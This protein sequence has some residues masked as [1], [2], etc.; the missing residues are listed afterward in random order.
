MLEKHYNKEET[1][2]INDVEKQNRMERL[3]HLGYHHLINYVQTQP[4]AK[5]SR[6]E[7]SIQIFLIYLHVHFQAH[8]I[9]AVPNI[10]GIIIPNEILR[11]LHGGVIPPLRLLY[12]LETGNK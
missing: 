10:P 9:I 3:V 1:L 11:E 2:D 6:N 5:K 8:N 7:V 12:D 4:P